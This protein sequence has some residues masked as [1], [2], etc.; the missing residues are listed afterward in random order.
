[1]SLTSINKRAKSP[2]TMTYY[3]PSNDENGYAADNGMKFYLYWPPA[4][5]MVLLAVGS[6]AV[7]MYFS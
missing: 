3:A 4:T 5:I 7:G 6:Y 1:V 2:V